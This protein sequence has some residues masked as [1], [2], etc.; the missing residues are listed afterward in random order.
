M[1]LVLRDHGVEWKV[2]YYDGLTYINKSDWEFL[3]WL[4]SQ[5]PPFGPSWQIIIQISAVHTGVLQK[6]EFI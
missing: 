2:S 3:V 4:R 5:D 6:R 1:M